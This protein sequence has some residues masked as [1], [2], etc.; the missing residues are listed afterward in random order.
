ML[1]GVN[2]PPSETLS[3]YLS[4]RQPR[5]FRLICFLQCSSPMTRSRRGA[6]F[7]LSCQSTCR[8]SIRSS[9]RSTRARFPPSR[10]ACRRPASV[11][12]PFPRSSCSL[13]IPRRARRAQSARHSMICFSAQASRTQNCHRALAP[14]AAALNG[15]CHLML[16]ETGICA[17]RRLPRAFDLSFWT[18]YGAYLQRPTGDYLGRDYEQLQSAFF[19]FCAKNLAKSAT[20]AKSCLAL[21]DAQF[22]TVA[23]KFVSRLINGTLDDRRW[24]SDSTS[25]S[26]EATGASSELSSRASASPF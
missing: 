16:K 23:L 19:T 14:L 11:S 24:L 21:T 6:A 7:R 12:S 5:F 2:R 9:H 3:F 4:R 13:R 10:S 17:L 1:I 20:K 15:L 22:S 8:L 26:A 18:K 25:A